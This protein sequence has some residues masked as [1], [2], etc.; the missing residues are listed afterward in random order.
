MIPAAETTA[1]RRASAEVGAASPP[2]WKEAVA[3][4]AEAHSHHHP[5]TTV[6]LPSFLQSSRLPCQAPPL[7]RRP[8]I[9]ELPRP[10][11]D[12][13]DPADRLRDT[14]PDALSNSPP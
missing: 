6:A 14:S 1:T 10:A 3:E 9:S 4:G 5:G 7:R 2:A 13:P 8:I 11:T 12:T